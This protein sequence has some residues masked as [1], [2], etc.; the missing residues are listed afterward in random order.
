MDFAK[1]LFFNMTILTS[2]IA[3][4]NQLLHEKIAN[5]SSPFRLKIL[6]GV[7]GGLLGCLLILFSIEVVPKTFL[8][9]RILPI[10][11]WSIY[12]SN[13]STVVACLIIGLF[14]IGFMG[15]TQSSLV[16]LIALILICLFCIL[17]N[18]MNTAR[19]V[20]WIFSTLASFLLMGYAYTILIKSQ[21]LVGEVLLSYFISI[22]VSAFITYLLTENISKFNQSI[23]QTRFY[24]QKDSLTGLNNVRQFDSLYNQAVKKAVTH[25]KN[26]SCLFLDIDF[27]K[28]VNDTYGHLDGNVVLTGL[29]ELLNQNCREQDI[30]SRNGGEEFS[31]ILPNCPL[32]QAIE[33]AERIRKAVEQ[34]K[35]LLSSGKCIQVTISIGVA[36]YPKET[37]S[38]YKLMEYADIAL[39][40]A[41]R[42]GRNCVR[43]KDM[44]S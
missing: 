9:L 32:S 26:L 43:T 35:F 38:A 33:V 13:L 11:I 27:F 28:K 30:I 7:F 2:F 14:R 5:E 12:T 37:E 1:D 40:N 29:S 23:A 10:I 18:R 42:S 36:S 44:L 34:H 31:V 4:C 20:K 17:I 8:D 39:Y 22:A 19:W 41:K 24:A 15:F 25:N 21:S 16:S 6:T 3:I